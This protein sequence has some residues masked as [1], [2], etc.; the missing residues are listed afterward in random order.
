MVKEL[1]HRNYCSEEKKNRI[2]FIFNFINFLSI[3]FGLGSHSYRIEFEINLCRM[4]P[5]R[6][7]FCPLMLVDM[8][9]ASCVHYNEK[10]RLETSIPVLIP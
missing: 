10:S 9:L 8:E 6:R 7:H 1:I 5:I 2:C 3:S 4:W